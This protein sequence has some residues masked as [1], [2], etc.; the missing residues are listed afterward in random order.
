LIFKADGDKLNGTISS[1]IGES[2]IQ[3]GTVKGDQI[4][5]SAVRN[6]NGNDVTFNYTGKITGEKM[7]L[8]VR[9]GDREFEINAVKQ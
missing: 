7:V 8:K 5:F 9:A 2:K 4:S 3:N 6:I 1:Q